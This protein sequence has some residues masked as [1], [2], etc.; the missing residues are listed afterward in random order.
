[1]SGK[2]SRQRMRREGIGKRK[3]NGEAKTMEWKGT[4]RERLR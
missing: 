1:M 4:I 2:E 3:L